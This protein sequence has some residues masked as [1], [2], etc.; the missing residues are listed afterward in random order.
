MLR[1]NNINKAFGDHEVLSGVTLEVERAKIICLAGGSGS[2]KST[3]LRIMQR[4][5]QPDS[6]TISSDLRTGFMFQDFQL[7]PH[8]TVWQ[9]VTYAPRVQGRDYK[10]RAQHLVQSLGLANKIHSYPRQLSGGQKQRV[11]LARTLVMAPDILFCD[12]PTSGLDVATIKDVISLIQSVRDMNVGVV[13]ASH[14]LDFITKIAD[15]I[16]VLKNGKLSSPIY[17][18]NIGQDIMNI[19]G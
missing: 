18:G 2:G 13:I 6:G 1:V 17:P 19:Y 12:E 10:E 3:L 9:N 8:M 5:E 16:H 15:V 14:D 4:L 7:F 11:A